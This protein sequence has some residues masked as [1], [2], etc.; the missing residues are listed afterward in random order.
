MYDAQRIIQIGEFSLK[1]LQHANLVSFLSLLNDN[2]EGKAKQTCNSSRQNSNFLHPES[3]NEVE[4]NIY[5]FDKNIKTAKMYKIYEVKA[6]ANVWDRSAPKSISI[7]Q[8]Q[9]FMQL[10]N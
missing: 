5:R 9:F 4:L 2:N 8:T 7:T 6:S 3:L 10:V 1:P